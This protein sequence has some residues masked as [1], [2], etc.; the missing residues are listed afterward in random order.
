QG[1]PP[2]VR[3]PSVASFV[4]RMLRET[5]HAPVLENWGLLWM[6]HSL[7]IFVLCLLT[8][9]MYW[10]GWTDHMPYLLLW[11]VGLVVWG[12]IFW[13]LRR[14]GGPVQFVERQ[15]AHVWAGAVMATI[16]IFVIE[17]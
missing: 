11:G 7:K 15:V 4:A 9:A 16:S 17:V 8:N 12:G 13:Q 3:S 5:H 6:W 1:E 10:A 2:S 14:R